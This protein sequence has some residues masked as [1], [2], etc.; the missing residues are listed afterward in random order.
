MNKKVVLITDATEEIGNEVGVLFASKGYNIVIC[1]NENR[2]KAYEIFGEEVLYD[3][4]NLE[5]ILTYYTR[6]NK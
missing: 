6:G 3:K 2:K 1:Y 5:D 4:P